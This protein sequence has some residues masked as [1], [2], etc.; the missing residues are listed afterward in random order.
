MLL[1]GGHFESNKLVILDE[2][3]V[4]LHPKWQIEYARIICQLVKQGANIVVTTHSPYMFEALSGFSAKE[5][6]TS[7]FYL[8]E[9]SDEGAVLSDVSLDSSIVIERLSKPL[10]DLNEELYGDF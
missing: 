4:N 8:A 7:H 1:K 9:Q 5:D 2:P 3:E 10:L 6:I